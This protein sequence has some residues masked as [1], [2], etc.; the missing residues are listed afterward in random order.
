MNCQLMRIGAAGF[1]LLSSLP[2]SYAMNP[3]NLNDPC[4]TTK[5]AAATISTKENVALI[6]DKANLKKIV[7]NNKQAVAKLETIHSSRIL[8]MPVSHMNLD[9]QCQ[10][11][12]QVYFAYIDED[13]ELRSR[14]TYLN[15]LKSTSTNIIKKASAYF[16]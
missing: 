13:R 9:N 11:G 16:S 5:E 8:V 4:L 6:F 3:V 7:K 15:R 2:M 10:Q 1:L 14:V 12:I